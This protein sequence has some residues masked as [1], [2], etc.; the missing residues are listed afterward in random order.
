LMT[1]SFDFGERNAASRLSA[2]RKGFLNPNK[3][4]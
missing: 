3:C 1:E 2:A 4:G